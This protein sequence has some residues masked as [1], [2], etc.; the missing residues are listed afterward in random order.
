ACAGERP[1]CD[2]RD[3][4]LGAALGLERSRREGLHG[5]DREPFGEAPVGRGRGRAR[6]LRREAGGELE[7]LILRRP[8]AARLRASSTRYGPSRRMAAS[9]AS[10]AILRDSAYGLSLG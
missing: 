1:G 10:A 9:S 2:R 4:G 7:H 3:Q 8:P 5:V 6:E